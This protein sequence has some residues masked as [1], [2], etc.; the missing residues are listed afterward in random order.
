MPFPA[1]HRLNMGTR[2]KPTAKD[3]YHDVPR[4]L[5]LLETTSRRVG[6]RG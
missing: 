1:S 5:R 2:N 4:G 6:S 3:N